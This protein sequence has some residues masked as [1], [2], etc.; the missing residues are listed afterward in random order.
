MSLHERILAVNNRLFDLRAQGRTSH[1]TLDRIH[2]ALANAVDAKH[3]GMDEKAARALT[4]AER[5]L[6]KA[7]AAAHPTLL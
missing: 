7:E 4:A 3:D 6:D 5:D 1:R 2:R